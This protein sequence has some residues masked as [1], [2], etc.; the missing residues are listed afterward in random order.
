VCT[1]D[2]IEGKMIQF[3]GHG[4]LT[5]FSSLLCFLHLSFLVAIMRWVAI[6]NVHGALPICSNKEYSNESCAV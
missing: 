1:Y 5:V 3:S 2:A 6:T 4:L